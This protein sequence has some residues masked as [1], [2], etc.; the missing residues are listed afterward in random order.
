V[1]S[2]ANLLG[3]AP[4]PSASL[5]VVGSAVQITVRHAYKIDLEAASV[6]ERLVDIDEGLQEWR[7]QHMKMVECTIG[8]KNGK[9]GTSG[10]DCLAPPLLRPVSMELRVIRSKF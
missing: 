10:A 2:R 8:R 3:V 7:Y 9:S 5:P 4:E 1:E 6:L